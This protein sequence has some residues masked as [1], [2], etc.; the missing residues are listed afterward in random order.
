MSVWGPV[1]NRRSLAHGITLVSTASHGG[2]IISKERLAQMPAELQ[3][4]APWAGRLHYEEDQDWAIVCLAFPK[5]FS[6]EHCQVAISTAKRATQQGHYALAHNLSPAWS[7]DLPAF[8][9]SPAG[10]A[11]VNRAKSASN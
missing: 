5:L 1:Q 8:L 3:A 9:A 10:Q 4:I 2:I 11:V 7:L 6:P